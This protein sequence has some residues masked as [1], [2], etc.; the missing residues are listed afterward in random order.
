MGSNL[1]VNSQVWIASPSTQAGPHAFAR[2]LFSDIPA[3][4]CSKTDSLFASRHACALPLQPL[5]LTSLLVLP[6]VLSL[7][8][9]YKQEPLPAYA[10]D[11]RDKKSAWHNKETAFPALHYSGRP[12]SCYKSLSHTIRCVV[13]LQSSGPIRI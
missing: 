10:Q 4:S 6:A 5:L 1:T 7:E 12:S 13:R 9:E 3:L 8:I 11:Y 2:L